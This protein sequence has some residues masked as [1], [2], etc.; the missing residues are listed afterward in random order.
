[1]KHGNPEFQKTLKIKFVHNMPPISK[2]P[3][4]KSPM[5][6]KSIAFCI[7]SALF[8]F[9][10]SVFAQ[11]PVT[12][13]VEGCD[14]EIEAY[15]SQVSPGE[16]R[17]LACFYAHE[18]KLSS[19]CEYALYTASAQLEQAVSALNY[20]AGECQNDIVSLCA[21]VEMGEG[22]ILD[23]L[24]AQDEAVSAQCKAAIEQVIE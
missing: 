20:L 8:A 18:D 23:C 17:M 22:R 21:N 16:G 11:D 24:A 5:K 19:K 1:M 2:S 13:V 3:K 15:C 7:F 14:V 4:E 6:L 12:T 10:G 9:S